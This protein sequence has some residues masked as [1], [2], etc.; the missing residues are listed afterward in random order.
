MTQ[1]TMAIQRIDKART[2]AKQVATE[3]QTTARTGGDV[4]K[5]RGRARAL[6]SEIQETEEAHR[7]FESDLTEFLL[8]VPNL[9]DDRLPDGD[10]ETF[11][12]QIRTWGSLPAFD[13]DPTDHV[14]LGER[15]G[16]FDFPRATKLSGPRFAVL[17]HRRSHRAAPA[18][19][20]R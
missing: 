13:F 18:R 17:R 9:P 16:I 5:L 1:R 8:G 3:I 10:S 15:L 12:V 7:Q 4:T 19:H 6:K 11:A 2:E 14:D 20:R